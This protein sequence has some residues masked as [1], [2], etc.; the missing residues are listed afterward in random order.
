MDSKTGL[1]L[2]VCKSPNTG[3]WNATFGFKKEL[4]DKL[5]LFQAI[6]LG[7]RAMTRR[8]SRFDRASLDGDSWLS[9]PASVRHVTGRAGRLAAIALTAVLMLA[10]IGTVPAYATVRLTI[11]PLALSFPNQ[12]VGTTSAAKNVTLTN[13]NS[14]SLQIDSVMPSAGDFSVSATDAAA[15]TSRP[16]E[17]ASSAWSLL[18]AR[19]ARGRER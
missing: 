18:R 15:L 8:H 4:R 14:S 12:E 13:P 6:S 16:A 5:R 17:T 1:G 2:C 10:A 3:V 19:P 11:S 9:A 7:G